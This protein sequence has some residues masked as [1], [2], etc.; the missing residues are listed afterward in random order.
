M[1]KLMSLA[2]LTASM[3]FAGVAS[4]GA[5]FDVTATTLS[6]VNNG[7]RT[8]FALTNVLVGSLQVTDAATLRI[9]P[10]MSTEFGLADIQSFQFNVANLM[11]GSTGATGVE[12]RAVLNADAN[13]FSSF[14]LL[15]NTPMGVGGCDLLCVTEF[16]RFATARD[17]VNIQFRTG[18][19][20]SL[21]LFGARFAFNRRQVQ[22]PE[23][24]TLGLLAFGL[25]AQAAV[26]RRRRSR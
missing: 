12:F 9:M 3:V 4:A 15:F 23:P 16:G 7:G 11:L 21:D 1:K 17:R 5:V 8:T 19:P 6:A 25:L 2:I 13:T 14:R 24:A 18:A 26:S 22:V 20:V 10:G